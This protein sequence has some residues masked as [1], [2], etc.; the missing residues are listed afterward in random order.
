[1]VENKEIAALFH[2][3]D[4]PD[5]L[6]YHSVSDKIISFGK[7][8]IPN[9]EN[10]WENTLQEDIQERI[11]QIIHKLHFRDL[12]NDFVT[13]KNNDCELL[14]GALL[15]A[16]YQYPEMQDTQ[17]LK[18]I[19][20]IRRNIWLELNNYLTP[21][22][23]ANVITS[24]LYNYYQQ[25]GIEVSY[26][27]PD[28]FLINKT[29]ENQRGN[30][31]SNGILYLILCQLLDISVNATNIPKQFILG[32]F[33]PQHEFIHPVSHTA[34]KIFFFIDPLNGNIHSH[35]DIEKYFNRI[36]ISPSSP[37]FR[38]VSNK[39]IIRFLLE[40][41]SKCFNNELNQYKKDELVSLIKLLD[42]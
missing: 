4:D 26:S 19:E 12:T 3:M 29:L 34:E 2:L 27:Q 5:E 35:K 40:E 11:E 42:E 38:P 23:Q 28:D 1:L 18:K 21:L 6:V 10:L 37:F 8:I 15:V 41:L 24:I 14:Q 33:D 25:K 36:S 22:E 32:Y 7:E 20:K 9:L 13:W 39:R 30:S 17:V 16:R 31:I